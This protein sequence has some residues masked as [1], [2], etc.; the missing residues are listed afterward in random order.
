MAISLSNPVNNFSEGIHK[1][2]CK[3]GQDD[4]KCEIYGITYDVCVCFLEYTNFKDDLI[5]CKYLI[6]NKNC[7]TKFAERFSKPFLNTYKFSKHDNSK[8]ILLLGK[9]V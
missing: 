2:K 5:E 6:C 9:G 8:F 7:Q 1:N 3:Y 4:K